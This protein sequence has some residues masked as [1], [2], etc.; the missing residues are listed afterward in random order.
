MPRFPTVLLALVLLWGCGSD[1]GDPGGTDAVSDAASPADGTAPP[2]SIS[3][4]D[5][6][7]DA[8][9]PDRDATDGSDDTD[10][11]GGAEDAGPDD[12]GQDDAADVPPPCHDWDCWERPPTAPTFVRFAVSSR[13]LSLPW[14]CDWY[15]VEDQ[16][17]LRTGHR[18]CSDADGCS[19]AVIDP[20][21]GTLP[22]HRAALNA[23]D[24]F[25]A[26]GYATMELVGAP[27]EGWT[28]APS[29]A[30][31]N[32]APVQMFLWDAQGLLAPVPFHARIVAG[33]ARNGTLHHFLDVIPVRPL[34]DRARAL[35]VVTRELR[36]A[37]G[38]P[39]GPD[40]EFQVALG[41]V[42]GPGPETTRLR[43][44]T[45]GDAIRAAGGAQL[46]VDELAMAFSYTVAPVRAAMR[47]LGRRFDE[48]PTYLWPDYG[49]DVD[50]DG[51]DDVSQPGD[52]GF[53][54]LPQAQLFVRGRFE[55]RD[56]RHADAGHT[57]VLEDGHPIEASRGPLSY[58]LA[59]PQGGGGPFP[60]AILLHGINTT[61]DQTLALARLLAA[62]GWATL[63]ID[64]PKHGDDGAGGVDFLDIINPLAGRDN[65]RQAGIDIQTAR[66]LLERW[67]AED[68]DL[69][70][71]PD[72][73]GVG[74][75]DAARVV[76]LGHSLGAMTGA[77][78]L[79]LAQQPEAAVLNVG[80]GGLM[81][82]V[83]SFLDNYGFSGLLPEHLVHGVEVIVGHVLAEGDPVV[84]AEWLRH[85]PPDWVERPHQI[86]LQEVLGDT[87]MPE[88][89]LEAQAAAMR[90]PIVGEVLK[91]VAGV[92][93]SEEPTPSAGLVQYGP[94]APH[95]LIFRDIGEAARQQS[96]HFL[97]TFRDAGTAEIV[98][99][100]PLD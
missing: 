8:G 83:R 86:L 29:E 25:G 89:C 65:W 44:G 16:T 10:G 68:L 59:L 87:T 55:R 7:A 78:G 85:A 77:I 60:T 66:G 43:A 76:L 72:G 84:Y 50:G 99:P 9:S 17:S 54:G 79:S 52:P 2:D 32:D 96:L 41:L 11:G 42:D 74:D 15:L 23:L 95:E 1:G 49:F 51:V 94:P 5:A 27:P 3:G 6:A 62:D 40:A 63:A 38:E 48:D 37:N 14:P 75:L 56:Y 97:R 12:A 88:A 98:H 81:H 80:G 71:F 58:Y 18:V 36:D 24:G 35:V 53:P 33:R 21:F 22:T 19:N 26:Y 92:A 70:P 64:L 34:P 91:E 47:D 82:F 90:L 100:Y 61:K 45:F 73:D 57:F 13:P 39:I 46:D 93:P 67:D 20:L 4:D 28:Q 69:V 30:L 31:P